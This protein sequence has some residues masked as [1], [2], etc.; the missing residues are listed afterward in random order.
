MTRFICGNPTVESKYEAPVELPNGLTSTL[1][2]ASMYADAGAALA[3]AIASNTK[4]IVTRASRSGDEKPVPNMTFPLPARALIAG[5]S[6][7]TYPCKQ[8]K[9]KLQT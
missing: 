2:P 5:N 4:A 1:I 3:P 6:A 9:V 8:P 7:R